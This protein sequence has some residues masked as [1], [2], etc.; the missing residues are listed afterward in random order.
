MLDALGYGE[1]VAVHPAGDALGRP[2]DRPYDAIL[3][4]AAAPK[5]PGRL[6]RQLAPRGRLVIPVGTREEQD[7]LRVNRTGNDAFSFRRLG[8]CR[9]V[10][11]IGSGGWV[12][13][14]A[15]PQSVRLP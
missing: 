8:P 14:P 1:R 10:P 2:D 3:V 12:S 5:V 11:L 7:L 13:A 6:L 4:T 15:A 9:F